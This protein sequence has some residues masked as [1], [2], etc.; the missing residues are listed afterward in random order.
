M[1]IVAVVVVAAELVEVNEPKENCGVLE[2]MENKDCVLP[3][4]DKVVVV[5]AELLTTVPNGGF[6]PK[7]N[8]LEVETA[9][10]NGL[11]DETVTTGAEKL[12]LKLVLPKVLGN[13]KVVVAD[14]GFEEFVTLPK[15]NRGKIEAVV[16]FDVTMD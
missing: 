1:N 14:I 11:I 7:V 2:A 16:L 5:S 6:I 10:V 12:L 8:G 15:L 4:I 9:V 13:E 3:N